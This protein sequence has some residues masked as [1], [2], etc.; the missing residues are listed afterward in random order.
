MNLK[1]LGVMAIAIAMG[2]LAPVESHAKSI[3]AERDSVMNCVMNL[4]AN[5]DEGSRLLKIND[6]S[7]S[8]NPNTGLMLDGISMEMKLAH[9]QGKSSAIYGFGLVSSNKSKDGSPDYFFD[10][11]GVHKLDIYNE[12][13]SL[14]NLITRR[15]MRDLFKEAV[16]SAYMACSK[17]LPII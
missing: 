13:S 16:K 4:G 17:L 15:A 2:S 5:V 9:S 6:L 10:D 12:K 11:I 7:F 14:D 3:K 1:S 8:A